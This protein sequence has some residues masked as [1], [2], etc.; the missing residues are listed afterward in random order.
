M[1]NQIKRIDPHLERIKRNRLHPRYL[2]L[3]VLSE[4]TV[5]M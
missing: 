5:L 1:A 4:L 3:T 2:E